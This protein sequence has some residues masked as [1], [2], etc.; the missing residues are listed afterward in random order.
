MLKG[1]ITVHK[2]DSKILRFNPLR[3]PHIRDLI[4]YLP[5]EY[6][7]VAPVDTLQSSDLLGLEGKEKCF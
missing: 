2:H 7:K 6:T 5:P 3:D 1:T 4:I